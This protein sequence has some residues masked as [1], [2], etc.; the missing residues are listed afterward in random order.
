LSKDSIKP[1]VRRAHGERAYLTKAPFVVSLL[2]HD[3][4]TAAFFSSR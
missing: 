1:R 2:N 3:G 4:S